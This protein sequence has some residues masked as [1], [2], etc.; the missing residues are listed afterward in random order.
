M[1]ISS[2]LLGVATIALALSSRASA[3]AEIPEGATVTV[4]YVNDGNI[5]IATDELSLNTC[6]P[7]E[8]AFNPYSYINF[9]PNNATINFYKDSN[10]NDA[11]FALDGYYGGYPGKARSLK[12]VGYSMD[13]RG[14]LLVGTEFHSGTQNPGGNPETNGQAGNPGNT[15]SSNLGTGPSTT[16]GDG[17]KSDTTS[18]ST[19]FGGVV[20]SLIVLSIG[21]VVFWKTA[22]KKMVADKGKGVLPYNRVGAGGGGRGDDILLSSSGRRDHNSFELGD[23]YDEDDEE[24]HS[25]RPRSGRGG[26]RYRDDDDQV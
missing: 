18:S 23:E 3:Q 12:W 14:E 26:G 25:R 7:S 13:Q 8:A 10:C 19:F 15:D 21:G 2:S 11:A 24:D 20:G 17:S 9:D 1:H 4:T 22:G 6:L 5:V 16:P